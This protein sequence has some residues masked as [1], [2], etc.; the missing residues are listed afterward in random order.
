VT[1]DGSTGTL[2]DAA[3]SMLTL[4]VRTK[5]AKRIIPLCEPT[6]L[7]MAPYYPIT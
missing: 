5:S 3:N 1:V 7:L 2:A 4:S 6:F